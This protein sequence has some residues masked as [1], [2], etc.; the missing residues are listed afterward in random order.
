MQATSEYGGMAARSDFMCQIAWYIMSELKAANIMRPVFIDTSAQN[1]ELLNGYAHF[2]KNYDVHL[3]HLQRR[4]V[5]QVS[6]HSCR[7]CGD[8]K[9]RGSFKH[10][11]R[12]NPLVS[13]GN[14]P[15][16]W[17]R[18]GFQ[19]EG[20][21]L[22]R[23][24]HACMNVLTY[25]ADLK[26][27]LQNFKLFD[28]NYASLVNV[29][30]EAIQTIDGV[31]DLLKQLGLDMTDSILDGRVGFALGSS[32]VRLAHDYNFFTDGLQDVIN[33]DT[34]SFLRLQ[35]IVHDCQSLLSRYELIG[36][37][38]QH[39]DWSLPHSLPEA[40]APTH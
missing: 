14:V 9:V 19:Q 21:V 18:F 11:W 28:S 32:S 12:R 8:A 3:V 15:N 36:D 31:Q 27:E 4:I 16:E 2:F 29:S 35:H 20:A 22:T 34:K 5:E 13:T 40:Y 6:S 17:P 39:L 30:L 1:I 10:F 23:F 24:E 38:L 25:Q 26:Q 37:D 7:K 33:N